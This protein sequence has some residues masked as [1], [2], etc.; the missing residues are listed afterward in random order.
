MA[1][2]Y[3]T[4]LHKTDPFNFCYYS[5]EL[6]PKNGS[7]ECL[8]KFK[9]TVNVPL[10]DRQKDICSMEYYYFDKASREPALAQYNVAII[11]FLLE[12]DWIEEIYS[13]GLVSILKNNKPGVDCFGNNTG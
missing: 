7:F 1:D 10:E 5:H 3:P 8:D 9:S 6:K 2:G 4:Y 13:N 11:N 12:N